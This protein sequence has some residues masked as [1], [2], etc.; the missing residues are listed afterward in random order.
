M[1]IIFIILAFAFPVFAAH[2]DCGKLVNALLK[3]DPATKSARFEQFYFTNEE[4]CDGGTNEMN[5]NLEIQLIDK[6]A[7][8]INEKN[9]FINTFTM[10]ESLGK[11]PSSRIKENHKQI[12]PQYRN[13]KF[14]IKVPPSQLALYRIV[15][16]SG[17]ALLGT[18][19]IK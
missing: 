13:V 3:Y 10:V 19:E 9:I 15:E 6:G 16:K 12:E 1:K 5:A 7:K 18:G 4:F 14:S 2:S 8:V 11:K 17:R